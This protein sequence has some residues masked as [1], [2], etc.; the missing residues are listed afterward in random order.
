VVVGNHSR[1]LDRLRGARRIFFAPS[2][3]AGGI[4]EGIRKYDFITKA[5]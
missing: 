1:E 2:P 3:C 5:R 4:L